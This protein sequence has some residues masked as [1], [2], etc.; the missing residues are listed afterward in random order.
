MIRAGFKRSFLEKIRLGTGG[1]Y[2]YII[3]KDKEIAKLTSELK[4]II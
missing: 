4:L 1:D 3:N 2:G